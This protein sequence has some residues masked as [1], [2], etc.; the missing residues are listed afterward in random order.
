MKKL[1][2]CDVYDFTEPYGGGYYIIPSGTDIS[3]LSLDKIGRKFGTYSFD[4]DYLDDVIG[5]RVEA[6]IIYWDNTWSE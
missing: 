4:Q 3:I 5:S 1:I 6:G 2:E